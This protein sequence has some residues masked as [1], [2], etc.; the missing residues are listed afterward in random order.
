MR[1]TFILICI[2]ITSLWKAQAQSVVG[3][4]VDSN[5]KPLS[6]VLVEVVAQSGEP[7]LT[8]TDGEYIISAKPNDILSFYAL[9]EKKQLVKVKSTTCNI[10]MGASDKIIEKGYGIQTSN[11]SSTMSSAS[12]DYEQLEKFSAINPEN[13]LYGILPGLTVLSNGGPVYNSSPTIQLRGVGTTGTSNPL[14]LVDGVDRL[15]SRLSVAEIESV[16]ILKDAAAVALYGVRGANGVI[17]I[18]TKR[19]EYGKMKVEVNYQHGFYTPFRLPKMVDA[20]TYANAINEALLN[21][22]LA[23]RYN[24]TEIE[25][26]RNGTNPNL[27]PNVD[28]SRE[29]TKKW[30]NNNE[31]DI[32]FKGGND[33]IRYFTFINYTNDFGLVNPIPSSEG[34]S[35]ELN[36]Y[37]LNLRSNLDIKVTNSTDLKINLMGSIDDYTRPNI[38]PNGLFQRIFST[39]SAAFPIKTTSNMWGGNSIYTNTNPVASIASTGYTRSQN[40]LL[41]SDLTLKQDLSIFLKGLTAELGVSYDN[42]AEYMDTQSKTFAYES[43][44]VLYGTNSDLNFAKSLNSMYMNTSLYG[45]LNYFLKTDVHQINALL[46]Y[47]QEDYQTKARNTHVARQKMA[48]SASWGIRDKYFID[49]TAVASGSSYLPKGDKFR[50]Y[51][52]ISAAWLLSSEDFLSKA[53]VINSLKI[54]TSFGLS[55][56]DMMSYELD[57]Q[58]YESGGN[59]WFTNTSIVSY[60]LKEGQLATKNLKP[61]LS[62]KTNFGIEFTGFDNTLQLSFDAFYDYRSNILVPGS[63][64]VSTILGISPAM[65]NGGIVKNKGVEVALAYQGKIGDF[66]YRV[67]GQFAY[68]KSKVIENGEGPKPYDYMSAKGYSIGTYFGLKSNGLFKDDADIASSVPQ[69]FSQVRPGD[70]KYIDRNGDDKVDE[71]DVEALGYSTRTPE[72]Y[73]GF[74]LSAEYKGFGLSAQF[75]G[76]ENFQVIRNTEHIYWTLR[77]N[78]N[79]SEWYY[80]NPDRWSPDNRENARYPR[81]TTQGNSNNFRANNVWMEDG[82]YLKLRSLELYY[83]LPENKRNKFFIRNVKFFVRGMNLF[84][85]DAVK[86]KDPEYMGNQYPTLSSY[87]TG[88]CLAF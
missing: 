45:K 69:V 35:T 1:L 40:R 86:D 49:A 53:S 13:A 28:W 17:L 74:N 29:T 26:F 59:Y 43:A 41:Y 21:D 82:A 62:K 38:S 5:G 58:L 25:L 81:L 56:N 65:T 68:A 31:L 76:I 63:N 50:F 4:V 42:M 18:T 73:Y 64:L 88:V 61:E 84:S 27:Y 3:K 34:Y 77:D 66:Q 11:Q 12:V 52:S 14:V 10:S 39:P 30:E 57:R 85:I 2:I 87:H 79:I 19:G 83:T 54:R 7:S 60:S 71:H 22:G 51:P 80:N 9:G 55:G 23:P 67:N 75:Q 20:P 47:N 37:R 48:A 24:D 72:I 36:Y 44:G 15:L 46:L 78:G 16:T 6:N 32:T 70:I 8:N 33:R